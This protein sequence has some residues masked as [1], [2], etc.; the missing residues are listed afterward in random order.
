MWAGGAGRGWQDGGRRVRPH[1]V[2][3]DKTLYTCVIEN[4]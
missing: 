3:Y 2:M 1:E 4:S